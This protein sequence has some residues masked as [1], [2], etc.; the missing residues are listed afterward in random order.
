[1]KFYCGN[2]GKPFTVDPETQFLYENGYIDKPDRCPECLELFRWMTGSDPENWEH[3]QYSDA[4][5]GL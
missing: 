1:M 5:P 4:D 2:C 3:E